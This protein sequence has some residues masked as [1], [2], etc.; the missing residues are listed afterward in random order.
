MVAVVLRVV[1]LWGCGVARGQGL[2]PGLLRFGG[3]ILPQIGSWKLDFL[4]A[5]TW[6]NVVDSV[7]V[8]DI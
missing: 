8:V 2:F 3:W 1:G 7:V 5:K 4:T 6:T